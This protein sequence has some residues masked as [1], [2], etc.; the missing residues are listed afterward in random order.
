MRDALLCEI[1]RGKKSLC[2]ATAGVRGEILQGCKLI[3][4]EAKLFDSPLCVR[5]HCA[6]HSRRMEMKQQ[7]SFGF[8]LF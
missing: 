1:M 8:F 2:G 7:I 5:V 4:D 6:S 3:K